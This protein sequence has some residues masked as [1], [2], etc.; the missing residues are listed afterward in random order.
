MEDPRMLTVAVVLVINAIKEE[1][2]KQ[3]AENN[4][5]PGVPFRVIANHCK[6]P[7]QQIRTALLT[8][9]QENLVSE[10]S[11]EMFTLTDI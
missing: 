1:I 5:I 10:I 6:I 2:K 7:E 11:S 8:L 9:K 4:H 3:E